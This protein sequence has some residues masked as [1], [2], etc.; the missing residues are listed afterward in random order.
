MVAQTDMPEQMKVILAWKMGIWGRRKV[1]GIF[2]LKEEKWRE[3][4]TTPLI[5][6]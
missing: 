6:L 1:E 5:A 4:R 3:N 2:A